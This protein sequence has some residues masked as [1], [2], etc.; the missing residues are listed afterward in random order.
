MPT[1]FTILLLETLY[2]ELGPMHCF[3][4]RPELSCSCA[5]HRHTWTAADSIDQTRRVRRRSC[6]CCRLSDSSSRV[7]RRSCRTNHLLASCDKNTVDVKDG[8]PNDS[9]SSVYE[10]STVRTYSRFSSCSANGRKE[11]SGFIHPA[12]H[13]ALRVSPKGATLKWLFPGTLFCARTPY[14]KHPVSH[15]HNHDCHS[16]RLA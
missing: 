13:A 4:A 14:A 12:Q 8:G 16:M 3:R 11:I 7:R 10:R 1:F 5:T 9:G 6:G 15:F 2:F